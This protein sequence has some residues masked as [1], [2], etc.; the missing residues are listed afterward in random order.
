MQNGRGGIPPDLTLGAGREPLLRRGAV[1]AAI[2]AGAFG[3]GV[4]LLPG[5]LTGTAAITLM[6]WLAFENGGN[7]TAKGVATVVAGR[8][9]DYRRA[10]WLGAG[11]T[12]LGSLAALWVTAGLLKLFS[13]G[14]LAGGARLPAALG[15]AVPAGAMLWVCLAT[16]LA[17][18]VSTTH[19][20]TGA[21]MVG[22]AAALGLNQV[23]WG[24][25]GT[26]VVVPLLG[27]PLLALVCGWGLWAAIRGMRPGRLLSALHIASAA[28]ASFARG[29]NDTPKI[30]A[31]GYFLGGGQGQLTALFLTTG[32]ATALGGLLR[33][34][35]V[36]RVLA[37]KVADL[38]SRSAL[39]A[40]I[41]AA[42]L[43]GA[44]SPLGLPVST[45]HVSTAAIAGMGLRRGG[46]RWPVL[47][48]IALS[49]LATL[50]LAGGLAAIVY[51]L[52][53][54]WA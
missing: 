51:V 36:A 27:G 22:G 25:L 38:D 50:P 13:T 19:A 15:L 9:L 46:V 34:L 32:A 54:V 10:L 23:L 12:M 14:L 45:T 16:R 29:L 2:L 7:D 18:P 28:A 44:A 41:A 4:W 49:W 6:A 43:V 24:A 8:L 1:P 40:N 30:A 47:R 39:C 33:G 35:P 11:A 5:R 17:L 21:V 48:A 52:L 37:E 26:K 31:L 3:L 53:S 20:I 42:L